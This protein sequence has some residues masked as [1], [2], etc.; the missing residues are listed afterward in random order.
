MKTIVECADCHQE[1]I[2]FRQ[3][4][5]WRSP[6]RFNKD[7]FCKNCGKQVKCINEKKLKKLETKW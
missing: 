4:N 6:F 2:I 3:H 1:R 5:C 7:F